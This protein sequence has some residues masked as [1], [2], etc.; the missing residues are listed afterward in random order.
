MP[1]VVV[2]QQIAAKE[3]M[4]KPNKRYKCSLA[5]APTADLCSLLNNKCY[6]IP[7]EI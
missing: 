1:T 3:L 7:Q 5:D 4:N 2:Q 6:D